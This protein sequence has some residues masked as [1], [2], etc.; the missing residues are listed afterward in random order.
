MTSS[1]ADWLRGT[2]RLIS[3][4]STTLAN[5]GPGLNSNSPCFW[6]KKWMPVRSEGRMSGVNWM[7]LKFPPMLLAKALSSMVLPVPGRSSKSTWPEAIR[8]TAI[9]R[10]TSSFPTMTW[11]QFLTIRSL[12]STNA[13]VFIAS[14]F[15]MRCSDFALL[16]G[17]PSGHCAAACDHP[18][19][20][21][22]CV[23]C[24]DLIIPRYRRKF[25]DSK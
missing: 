22:R 14:P 17:R 23:Q 11:L 1:R 8:H 18:W 9:W 10:I 19:S 16:W 24:V 6:L 15:Q 4:A 5:R 25:Q 13:A 3:S 20:I 21:I 7:R 2:A 12:Y